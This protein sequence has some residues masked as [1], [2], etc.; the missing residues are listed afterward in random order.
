MKKA[1][2]SRRPP[3]YFQSPSTPGKKPTPGTPAEW[4]KL[5]SKKAAK[6]KWDAAIEA[7][8]HAV[9]GDQ[10]NLLYR[11][12]LRGAQYRKYRNN[13]TGT[14]FT[15][16]RR[17]ALHARIRASRDLGKWDAVDRTAE[18]ALAVNPWDVEFNV[19]LG[20]ACRARGFNDVALFAYEVA[21][22]SAPDRA[23]IRA[24]R[25]SLSQP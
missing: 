13:L 21:L 23:D 12:K 9:D 7:F 10:G 16:G 8:R 14:A 18:D 22:A 20:H 25:D 6:E 1:P 19:E 24:W 2:Q 5:G 15:R 3:D 11:E 17:L 4:F